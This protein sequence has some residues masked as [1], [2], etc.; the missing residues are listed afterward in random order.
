MNICVYG[1]ASELIDSKYKDVTYDLCFNLAKRGH[2]LVF[3]GGSHG[4]MGASARGFHDGGGTITGVIPEFFKQSM[5]E[6]L[7]EY[8]DETIWCKTMHERKQIMEERADAF[9]IAPG[10][11]GTYDEFFSVLTEKQL[12]TH[13]KPIAVFSPFKFYKSIDGV[14]ETAIDGKFV[15]PT[16]L[17]LFKSFDNAFELIK[18]IESDEPFEFLK[19]K[20]PLKDG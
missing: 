4:V 18:Y 13:I 8:S 9:I 10:G 11:V 5:P 14:F 19:D 12:D 20:K 1:S 6:V 3:G 2:S 7:Y 15:K 17:K 16:C